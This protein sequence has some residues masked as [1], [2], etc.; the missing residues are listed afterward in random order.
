[1]MRDNSRYVRKSPAG[2]YFDVQAYEDNEQMMYL[3]EQRKKQA[4]KVVTSKKPSLAT[5]LG[6]MKQR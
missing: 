6:L 4:Q 3:V 2:E 5:R 1:M